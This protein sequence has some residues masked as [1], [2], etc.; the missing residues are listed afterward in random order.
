MSRASALRQ[1][2][3]QAKA[4]DDPLL[5]R[6]GVQ[7]A[8]TVGAHGALGARRWPM[9]ADPALVRAIEAVRNDGYAVIEDLL[10]DQELERVDVAVS[11]A[12]ADESVPVRM[13]DN[14]GV[15][16][17]VR[18]RGD[19]PD[20]LRS[21]IDLFF[22]HPTVLALGS[23]AERLSLEPG[24]GRCTIQDQVV[25][26]HAPDREAEIHADTFQPTH[27][28]WLYL[29]DVSEA[30]G[31]LVFYPGSH[32]LRVQSLAAV[33][34]ESVGTNAGS[35]R[36]SERELA[37]SGFE[38]RALLCRRNSLV[39]ANTHGYHGRAQ[40]APGG[41]RTSLSIELRSD[42]FRRPAALG[43]DASS[44]RPQPVPEG[45]QI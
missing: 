43:V 21:D 25:V 36:I 15:E 11:R 29:T 27:K 9:P 3:G 31:P 28:L 17:A 42:P 38:R 22:G 6:L 10:T 34:R 19:L 20:D 8:R 30:D 18:W 12:I 2:V 24:S 37:R 33:Y 44:A 4:I 23:A 13:V 26:G 16:V 14:G 7:V 39:I 1:V 35:R 45:H 41:H 32:R 5:N 40:G